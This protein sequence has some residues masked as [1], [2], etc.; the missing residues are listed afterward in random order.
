MHTARVAHEL[1]FDLKR[2]VVRSL[3]LL[4][5]C[6]EEVRAGLRTTQIEIDG[7]PFLTLTSA[8]STLYLSHYLM[9]IEAVLSSS[10]RFVANPDRTHFSGN[11]RLGGHSGTSK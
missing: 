9:Q 2:I 1:S 4:V 7:D 5:S 6:R 8:A 10:G 3:V 11:V